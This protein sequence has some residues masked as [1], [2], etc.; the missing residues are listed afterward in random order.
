MAKFEIINRVKDKEGKYH[1]QALLY[2]DKK[3]VLDSLTEEE[4]KELIKR[5][6]PY[7]Q[8]KEENKK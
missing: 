7:V 2:P 6:S 1:P 4:A 8:L 3:F 5:S